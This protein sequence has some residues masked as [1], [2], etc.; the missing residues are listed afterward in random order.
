MVV[1]CL[2][3]DGERGRGFRL[4]HQVLGHAG[5]GADISRGQTTDLQG[6]VLANL[7]SGLKQGF[8]WSG[9]NLTG[10][11]SLNATCVNR[12]RQKRAADHTNTERVRED[13]IVP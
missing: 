11:D 10:T 7:I 3:V 9:C 13:S 5:V 1:R 8:M 2:T 12:H 6:V 4:A